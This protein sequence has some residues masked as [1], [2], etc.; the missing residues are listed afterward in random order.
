[1]AIPIANPFGVVAAVLYP[2][3]ISRFSSIAYKLAATAGR[4]VI[5]VAELGPFAM[6]RKTQAPFG[7]TD[8]EPS[9]E[10]G[11]YGDPQ[12]EA[13]VRDGSFEQTIYGDPQ[14][15][16]GGAQALDA[17]A[18]LYADLPSDAVA[19]GG[20]AADEWEP[21]RPTSDGRRVGR[22]SSATRGVSLS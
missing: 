7:V 3:H 16:L 2:S 18:S 17:E 5:A 9:D 21:S 15:P 13:P 19:D 10:R 14:H 20:W 22:P 4:A 8:E 6:V 11:L 12:H 1:M